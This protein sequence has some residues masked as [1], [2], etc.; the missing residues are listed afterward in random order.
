LQNYQEWKGRDKMFKYYDG[1]KI[2]I[3]KFP[4][5]IENK[6]RFKL[7][8]AENK[9]LKEL[10]D[11]SSD[12]IL[13]NGGL[14]SKAETSGY[15][16]VGYAY[17]GV[18]KY[19]EY[20]GGQGVPKLLMLEG[21]EL[22]LTDSP[23]YDNA[24]ILWGREGKVFLLM[25]GEI[26]M[27]VNYGHRY[28]IKNR[29]SRTAIAF[30]NEW[31]Y[32]VVSTENDGYKGLTSESLATFCKDELGCEFAVEFDS[33]GSTQEYDGIKDEYAVM[34]TDGNPRFITDCFSFS[35]SDKDL[36]YKNVLAKPTVKVAVDAGHGINTEGRQTLD[37]T[38]IK[39]WVLND[40]V[41][42]IIARM[43]E[44]Y[45]V[46]I[47]RVDDWDDGL[48]DIALMKRIQRAN[49]W[50]ADIYLSIHHNAYKPNIGTGVEIYRPFGD[51]TGFGERLVDKMSNY[52]GLPNRGCKT[53]PY[54]SDKP[55]TSY[56]AVNR[57]TDMLGYLIEGGFM[58]NELDID[59]IESIKGAEA[60]ARA[61]VESLIEQFNLVKT[62]N[63]KVI[64]QPNYR[65]VFT[66]PEMPEGI[67]ECIFRCSDVQENDEIYLLR[68]K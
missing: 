51:N 17:D 60:Y 38:P 64:E 23:N 39:E 19:Q 42:D 62:E 40:R 13:I 50:G 7:H 32:F 5:N 1:S 30:N 16:P 8:I 34:S 29:D 52:T 57:E 59:V 3:T 4:N 28:E 44:G 6:K 33:G 49:E 63:E 65:K 10:K 36:S 66:I 46:E 14:Y 9:K 67:N 58:S 48:D 25:R 2:S 26:D 43:F 15:V 68:K 53:K 35:S 27:R 21:Y 11:F 22:I 47:L 12:D 56:Y 37:D 45:N 61:I 24:N 31:I 18:T 54:S 20:K 55:N 41:A